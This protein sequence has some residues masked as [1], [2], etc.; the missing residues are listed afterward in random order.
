ME[1]EKRQEGGRRNLTLLIRFPNKPEFPFQLLEI[2]CSWIGI[3]KFPS[4]PVKDK[5]RNGMRGG[6][7]ERSGRIAAA[8]VGSSLE[9]R[10]LT[11]RNSLNS[12][13]LAT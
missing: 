2:L 6:R 13:D 7:G 4:P 8:R 10:H 3:P 9:V 1:E 5:I 11:P 12:S